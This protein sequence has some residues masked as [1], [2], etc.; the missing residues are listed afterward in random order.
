MAI[1]A[2]RLCGKMKKIIEETKVQSKYINIEL[3]EAIAISNINRI[4]PSSIP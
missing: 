1:T 4:I 3:T 2:R